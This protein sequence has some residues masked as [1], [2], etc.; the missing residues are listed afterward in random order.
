VT[1]QEI[2][3]ISNVSLTRQSVGDYHKSDLSVGATFRQKA[4][5][6]WDQ[7]SIVVKETRATANEYRLAPSAN[8]FANLDET[9]DLGFYR[10]SS[11]DQQFTFIEVT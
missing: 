5:C 2:G 4:F 7:I 1:V 8:G 10:Q 11:K 9:L 3:Y 6:P